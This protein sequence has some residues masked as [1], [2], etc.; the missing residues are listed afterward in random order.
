MLDVG[1]GTG[2]DLI[3]LKEHGVA[4]IGVDV[5][6][7]M[8]DTAR[9]RGVE[10]VCVGAGEALP[11]RTEAFGGCRIERVLMHTVK[12]LAL[13]QEVGRCVRANGLLAMLEP[14]W[15]SFTVA[16]DTGMTNCGWLNSARHPGAGSQLWGLA[17]AAGF[18]VLDQ[19]EELSVWRS[20]K[21]LDAIV[22]G[23]GVA[24]GKA[25]TA[26]RID[27]NEGREWLERQMQREQ[28]GEFVA[29]MRKVLVVARRRR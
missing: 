19:V 15:L 17:E 28:A 6:A 4:A 11:F 18:E 27:P 16:D 2:S 20:L 24:V 5:S 10:S 1:C 7:V 21:R 12:P 8:A 26:G 23:A 25:I 22:G 14:D 29:R 9:E 3:L 13:V